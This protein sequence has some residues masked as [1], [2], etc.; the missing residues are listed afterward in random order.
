MTLQRLL[1]IAA[2]IM[3][4]VLIL[5]DIARGGGGAFPAT[6]AGVTAA[7]QLLDGG[8]RAP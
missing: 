1:L 7:A 2:A 5:T 6:G 4:A 3:T 8:G